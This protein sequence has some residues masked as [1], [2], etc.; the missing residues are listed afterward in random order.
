MPE[1]AGP[2]EK[3]CG[4]LRNLHLGAILAEVKLEDGVGPGPSPD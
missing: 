3:T 2:A 1:G 4:R